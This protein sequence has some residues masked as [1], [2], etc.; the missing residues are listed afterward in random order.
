MPF[1]DILK[2]MFR[3]YFVITTG[4]LLS[5]TA[6]C[7]L[8][9]PDS[10]FSVTELGYVLISGVLYVLPDL[11]FCAPR[12]LSKRQWLIRKVFHFLLLE[13]TVI[14]SGHFLFR[15]LRSWDLT[16]HIVMAVMVLVVYLAVI[17]IGWER[18]RMNAKAINQKLRQLYQ[19]EKEDA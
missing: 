3:D 19:E 10:S 5:M 17:W 1:K 11:V 9:M 7:M 12:E 14:G 18:E 4:V 6:F 16:Q 15:W 2:Q 13:V 8:F